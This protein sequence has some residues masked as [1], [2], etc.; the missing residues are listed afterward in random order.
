MFTLLEKVNLLQKAPI[1]HGVRTE[2]LAHV[3]AIAEEV[4]FEERQLLYRETEAADTM[5]VVLEG[6]VALSR[7]GAE[8]RRL[9]A[10]QVA[11]ALPLLAGGTQ[12]ESAMVTK[13]LRALRI[14]QQD[15]YD[16]MADDFSL[17]R[18]ML[19]ALVGMAAGGA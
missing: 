9:V 12:P 14:D 19:R 4:S 6:E 2:S 5:F 8:T 7:N 15:F 13:P 11:G 1:F 16:V 18:G 3:A 10:H 17:T